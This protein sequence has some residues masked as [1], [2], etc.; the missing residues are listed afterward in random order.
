[1]RT[2]KRIA[3]TYLDTALKSLG[4]GDVA[5]DCGANVGKITRMFAETGASVIA[6][7]PDPVV[8]DALSRNL[9]SRPNVSLH[10]AAVGTRVGKTT[11]LRSPYYAENPLLEAEKNTIC[12]DALTRRKEGGWQP[13]DT[14]NVVEVPVIDL[15]NLVQDLAVQ[16]GRVAVLKLDI[17][18]MEIPILESLE[19]LCLFR[20][21]GFTVAELHPRRFPG[22]RERIE[23]LRERFRTQ[24]SPHHVNLD[25]G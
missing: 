1:M 25:W 5:I 15:P 2:K 8:F 10:A 17:E 22:Q 20:L 19:R 23:T 24:Y 12:S 7:E 16:Y 18:G 9:G 21:I 3:E 11:L 4:V 14:E 6:F 13:M